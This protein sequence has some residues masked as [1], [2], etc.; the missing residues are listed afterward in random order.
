MSSATCHKDCIED[1]LKRHLLDF[2]LDKN[3][4]LFYVHAQVVKFL[5]VIAFKHCS[6]TIVIFIYVLFF[7]E[8]LYKCSQKFASFFYDAAIVNNAPL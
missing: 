8:C 7:T 1:T 5:H 6:P 2:M 4:V 3:Y